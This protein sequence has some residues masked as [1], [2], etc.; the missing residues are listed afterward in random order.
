MGWT[1]AGRWIIGLSQQGAAVW[2]CTRRT[3][4]TPCLAHLPSASHGRGQLPLEELAVLALAAKAPKTVEGAPWV[5]RSSG[6]AGGEQG[7][8][9]GQLQ[10]THS[11]AVARRP[12]LRGRL[13]DPSEQEAPFN[14][15]C[16]QLSAWCAAY[17][18]AHVPH[19]VFDAPLL[20]AW[21]RAVRREGRRGELE[22]WKR[23]AL[24]ALGFEWAV[25]KGDAQWYARMH[26]LRHYRALTGTEAP[27]QRGRGRALHGG[28][29]DGG[30][31]VHPASHDL[32]V[33][34]ACQGAAHAEGALPESKLRALAA[35][36][37]SLEVDVAAAARAAALVGLNSHERKRAR[38]AWRRADA[39]RAAATAIARLRSARAALGVAAVAA[40]RARVRGEAV[41]SALG[42]G[43]NGG[44]ISQQVALSD[45]EPR[46]D[47]RELAR[48]RVGAGERYAWLPQEGGDTGDGSARRRA[49]PRLAIRDQKR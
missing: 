11:A 1:L 39:A 15:M 41:R 36:G 6:G 21:V 46:V 2:P 13:P 30:S 32:A 33:W 28:G 12:R 16:R 26:S 10:H 42:G 35:L 18:T 44:T 37:V 25:T 31:T 4:C 20:G 3:P 14:E 9:V 8:R 29:T 17:G 48:A 22:A 24:N 49:A 43:V 34:L 27:Q 40:R 19:R 45:G 7:V 23:E 38:K 5:P 47:A